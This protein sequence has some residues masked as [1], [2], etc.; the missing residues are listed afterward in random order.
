[1]AFWHPCHTLQC[2]ALGAHFGWG[3]QQMCPFFRATHPQVPK[4]HW[5]GMPTVQRRQKITKMLVVAK[6]SQRTPR[7]KWQRSV[8]ISNQLQK[9]ASQ[10]HLW[11][12]PGK[13]L[14]ARANAASQGACLVGATW[15]YASDLRIF[16]SGLSGIRR[17]FPS[18]LGRPA[19]HLAN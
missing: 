14:A 19:C 11:A 15:T 1:M 4:S 3:H 2:W 5:T 9:P 17:K 7:P 10:E 8:S 18:I 6:N 12:Y 13:I 16:L